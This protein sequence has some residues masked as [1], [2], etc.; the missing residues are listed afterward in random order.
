MNPKI[1]SSLPRPETTTSLLRGSSEMPTAAPARGIGE[2]LT[3]FLGGK[4]PSG[5]SKHLPKRESFDRIRVN[6][7]SKWLLKSGN[8]CAVIAFTSHARGEGVSTVVAGLARS[9]GMADPGR[10]LVID[11]AGNKQGVA[12]LLGTE[13]P[14]PATFQDC[15]ADAQDLRPC[16]AHA[17]GHGVDILVLA[18][19]GPLRPGSGE[20]A[21]AVLASLRSKYR[22]ILVDS[23]A[24]A[25]GWSLCWLA[26]SNYRVLIIDSNAATRELLEHQ[27]DEL[28]RSGM[29]LDGFIL[30]KRTYPIPRSLYWLAR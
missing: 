29:A 24:L 20:Q 23:G 25:A 7:L 27:R 8:G 19:A 21:K 12:H 13:S 17:E 2:K 28:E 4:I 14:P 22:L 9:F 10:V 26:S 18:D 30:N 6:M 5:V 3:R 15:A 16:I 1:L 11:A